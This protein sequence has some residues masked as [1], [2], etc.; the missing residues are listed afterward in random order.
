[1]TPSPVQAALSSLPALSTAVRSESSG[2][3]QDPAQCLY[4]P[5]CLAE[6]AEGKG[7]RPVLLLPSV[8]WDTSSGASKILW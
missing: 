7:H 8:S 6:R 2:C 3:R 5:P 4:I 1:M